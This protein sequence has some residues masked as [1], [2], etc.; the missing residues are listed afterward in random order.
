MADGDDLP[1]AYR[2]QGA[3]RDAPINGLRC[4]DAGYWPKAA[5]PRFGP[6]RH[7]GSAEETA[8]EMADDTAARDALRSL[9]RSLGDM[10]EAEI[11]GLVAEALDGREM[12]PNERRCY[13]EFTRA[14]DA[15]ER[16]ASPAQRPAI[17]ALR[18]N[19]ERGLYC[20]F[21]PRAAPAPKMRLDADLRS[22]GLHELARRVR[23]EVGF[24]EF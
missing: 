17:A 14:L 21:G 22:A 6:A 2:D 8:A 20:N 7:T 18:A 16:A 10:S 5:A 19:A 24:A 13:E 11:D 12:S 15:A 1:P 23:D 4:V 3:W 9:L